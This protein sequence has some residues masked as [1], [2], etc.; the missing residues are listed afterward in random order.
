MTL[1]H[2]GSGMRTVVKS[3]LI[4]MVLVLTSCV[5]FDGAGDI[6]EIT[7]QMPLEEKLASAIDFGGQTF[8]D[9]VK[10]ISEQKKWSASEQI[11][12]SL[13]IQ[14]V[15]VWQEA[16][17][18]NATKLYQRS[19]AKNDDIV[20]AKLIENGG[21]L[22]A[23]VAWKLIENSSNPKAL[24]IIDS[25][26]T[27]AIVTNDLDRHLIPEMANAV[28]TLNVK[29]VYGVLKVGLFKTGEPAFVESMIRL[30]AARSSD[31]LFDYL[32]LAED[33]ELRQR[34][35]KSI[36]TIT[37]VQILDYLAN[38]P[39]TFGHN[40]LGKIF[41]Y[42]AS[43]NVGLRQAARRV[44]DGLVPIN[45]QILAFEL[46][47]QPKWV[48]MSLIEAARREITANSKTLLK[49][50]SLMTPDRSIEEEIGYLR[51]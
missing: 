44:V 7:A 46:S 10:S 51:L 33:N 41:V 30:Y 21:V 43:R 20:F 3:A 39:M 14:N 13:I 27:Q 45:P 15:E 5:S 18:L 2:R 47:K 37:A 6:P 50:L 40:E 1:T 11:L 25:V 36:D 19:G 35:L 28:A 29:S 23:K 38:Q 24:G 31:D 9:V 12:A 48:Q 22:A 8:K 42:A 26:L 32:L 4:S 34:T 49:E 17:L 16:Q